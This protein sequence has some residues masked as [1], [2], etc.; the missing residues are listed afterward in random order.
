MLCSIYYINIY[1]KY[2]TISLIVFCS[3][4]HHLWCSHSNGYLFT[5][6]DSM[7]FSH[8]KISCF[9]AKAHLVF[10]WCLYNKQNN[11]LFIV[12]LTWL[13]Y[14]LF[15]IFQTQIFVHF[16][17][18]HYPLC[19]IHYPQKNTRCRKTIRKYYNIMRRP[20]T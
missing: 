15:L 3:E 11:V 17:Y 14:S 5:C 16:F 18:S 7:L 6:E 10:H 1:E 12:P 13:C 8:L 9:G 2:Q 19:S 20:K 4:R